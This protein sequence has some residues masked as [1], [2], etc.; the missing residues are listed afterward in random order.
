MRANERAQ[1][2][3]VS[4][5]GNV[6]DDLPLRERVLRTGHWRVA[7]AF[8][9]GLPGW[10]VALPTRHVTV[11]DE[12]ERE[13]AAELGPLLCDLS[14]AL[15][16]VTGC[17]KTYV[18][19]FAEADGFEHVHFHVVPRMPD[20]PAELQGP[21]VFALLG[22]PPEQQVPTAQMDRIAEA[23]QRAMAAR[24]AG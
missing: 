20:Q 7:H 2:A 12:L 3:C 5:G 24:R 10:L 19:L 14:A 15:R 17:T 18:S 1:P 21:R 11:L 9:S 13:E 22:L 4:C 6:T 8:D 16:A 23:L